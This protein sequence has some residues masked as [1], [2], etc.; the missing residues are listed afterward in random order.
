[1]RPSP[2]APADVRRILV[3]KLS[4]LGDVVH[5]L[6]T[7]HNL[8]AVSGAEVDWLVQPEFADLVRACPDVTRILLFPRRGGLRDRW[9]FF[10][11]LRRARYDLVADLQGLLKSAVPA[12]LA[13]ARL[14][15]GPSFARE[16]TRWLYTAVAGPPNRNRHAVLEVADLI[17]WL[18]WPETPVEFPLRFPPS[19]PPGPPP[20]IA[21]VPCSRWPTKNWPVEF[22]H[23]LAARLLAQGATVWI[24][25]SEQDRPV[26]EAI[27][28]GT[29][30]AERVI[31]LAGRTSL[32]QLGSLLTHADLAITVDSGP[33]HLAAALGVP[34]LALFGPTDPVRTGPYGA[35]SRVL[36]VPPLPC[37]PCLSDRCA[38]GDHACLRNLHPSRV[39]A[40]AMQ[41]LHIGST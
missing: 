8:R 11:D 33:M 30:P 15:V 18:G 37:M 9:R 5:A 6:P 19:V 39:A 32:A 28:A 21:L 31:N 10:W 41:M 27:A 40:E 13:R 34:V 38:R 22:F 4:S 25:G 16:G 20:R 26:A 12:C 1:M 3:V 17:R 2:P 24:I 7:V 14:R 35:R 36:S 29:A 23:A